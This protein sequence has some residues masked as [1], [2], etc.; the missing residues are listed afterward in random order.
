[1]AVNKLFD[2]DLRAYLGKPQQ[3]QLTIADGLG[4]SARISTVGG[5]SW[6]YRYRIDGVIT[7]LSLG[8]YPDMSL[9]AARAER[10]KCRTWLA[11]G[12]NPKIELRLSKAETL[13]PI[14]VRDA[15]EFWIDNYAKTKRVNADKH[16]EQFEKWILPFVGDVPL[17]RM[18]RHHW[19]EC[20]D[21]R[22]AVE[23][24]SNEKKYANINKTDLYPVAA[25]YVLQ[26]L[27][28]AL[29][30]CSRKG[31]KFD[32]SIINEVEIEDV[33][34]KKQA[35]R[36][37]RLVTHDKIENETVY[38]DWSQLTDLVRWINDDTNN[39]RGY[40]WPYWKNLLLVCLHFGCRTQE[41]RLS[42]INE[43]DF[44][45]N[46][47]TVPVENNKTGARD[48]SIGQDGVIVRPIPESLRPWLIGLAEQNKD[49]GLM[50][51]EIK[52]RE[53][54]SMYGSSI[55]K[56]LGHT[57]KWTLHDLRRTVAT[58]LAAIGFLPHVV[59]FV[60]GHRL[61]GVAGIYNHDKYLVEQMNALTKWADRLEMLKR[62]TS[63][64]TFLPSKTA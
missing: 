59:E 27:R 44:T 29:K 5:I 45:K 38:H 28:Q 17:E 21:K 23:I 40:H 64:V 12:K 10:D 57:E 7:W 37:R 56:K 3:K 26:N 6:L 24:A 41:I 31:Y 53:Q 43:W 60:L 48:K 22:R 47:W 18:E 52:S 20:F 25:A 55:Y 51:G 4:L 33:G 46:L 34:G 54:V 16:K 14:T 62:D 2:K 30:V 8:S 11:D 50:L 19:L 32:K 15:L 42:K 35:K 63:N 61:N 39:N 1:M 36:S 49:S 9:N 13:K 58:G